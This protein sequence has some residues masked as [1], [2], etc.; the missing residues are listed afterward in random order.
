MLSIR[1]GVT[2]H[3]GAKAGSGHANGLS[4]SINWEPKGVAGAGRTSVRAKAHRAPRG[5]M[6]GKYASS[7]PPKWGDWAYVFDFPLPYWRTFTFSSVTRPLT[8][9]VSSSTRNALIFSSASTMSI[10][11]GRSADRRRIFVV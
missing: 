7:S 5:F 6:T 10:T 2:P 3:V 4:P 8:I 11:M 9:M 1:M